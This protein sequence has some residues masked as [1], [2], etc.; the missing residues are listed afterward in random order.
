[1]HLHSIKF[2]VGVWEGL[3]NLS[4]NMQMTYHQ[5]RPA[6]AGLMV[7]LG[8]TFLGVSMRRRTRAQ[9]TRVGRPPHIH[10]LRCSVNFCTRHLTHLQMRGHCNSEARNGVL[11]IAPAP[12]G[13]PGP[14]LPGSA[15]SHPRASR[16][17]CSPGVLPGGC[18][19]QKR[20]LAGCSPAESTPPGTQTPRCPFGRT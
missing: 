12:A 19:P 8:V 13:R 5:T 18:R 6:R 9:R 10:P 7:C 2:G 4:L 15:P 14:L 17:E 1:M 3:G 20:G 11:G 16:D